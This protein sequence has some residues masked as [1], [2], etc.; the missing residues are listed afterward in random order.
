M[1]FLTKML[2]SKVHRVGFLG[3]LSTGFVP[4]YHFN[5]FMEECPKISSLNQVRKI[6]FL[7]KHSKHS[8]H[9]KH[10]ETKSIIIYS[11]KVNYST[12]N[13]TIVE[14]NNLF[15]K[16]ENR[17]ETD[18][19]QNKM[20][21]KLMEDESVNNDESIIVSIITRLVLS[22]IAVSGIIIVLVSG[23]AL[24]AGIFGFLDEISNGHWLEAFKCLIIATVS[25]AILSFIFSFF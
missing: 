1:K 4:K 8:N 22:F 18:T 23:V 9:S 5:V 3:R 21:N 14:S 13:N 2:S 11:P 25:F 15:K 16:I 12:K 10:C 7:V 24:I 6:T 17:K 19:Y 20:N